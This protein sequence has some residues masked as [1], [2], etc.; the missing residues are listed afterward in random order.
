M[1]YVSVL[2]RAGTKQFLSYIIAVPDDAQLGSPWHATAGAAR[3]GRGEIVID[4]A[5]ADQANL[6]L[7]DEVRVLGQPFKIAGLTEGTMSIVSS[8]AFVSLADMATV[9]GGRDVISYVLV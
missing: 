8:V 6:T 9:Q 5:I 4:R 7:G 2:L 1:G 3:P